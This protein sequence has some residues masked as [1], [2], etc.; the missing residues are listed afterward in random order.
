MRKLNWDILRIIACFL[1][2]VNHTNS[3]VFLS[4]A[5]SLTWFA[6]LTYFFLCK[7]A[8][9]LFVMISGALLLKKE[10][11]YKTFF[12]KRIL[13]VGIVI[14]LF[15]FV[16]YVI[17]VL[18]TGDAFSMMSFGAHIYKDAITNA[19]WYLYLYLG[20]LIMLPLLQKKSVTLWLKKN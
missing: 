9:P 18:K 12:V 13:K 10:E 5:P 7:M 3:D 11:D 15:S 14:L 17:D 8:V 16:Y 4:M 1:V 19:Y 2:I 6:S 20:L